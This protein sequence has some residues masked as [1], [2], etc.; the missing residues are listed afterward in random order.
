VVVIDGGRE[1]N[2]R[3]WKGERIHPLN[4]YSIGRGFRKRSAWEK[5]LVLSYE[6]RP[7]RTGGTPRSQ[8]D[9]KTLVDEG[10]GGKTRSPATP[11]SGRSHLV[12]KDGEEQVTGFSYHGR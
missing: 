5:T 3:A 8:I 12:A 11:Q 2:G 9:L 1:V 6:R 4:I 10:P 7:E